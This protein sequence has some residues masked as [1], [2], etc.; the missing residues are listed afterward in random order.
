MR[1]IAE[2]WNGRRNVGLRLLGYAAEDLEF[3]RDFPGLERLDLQVPV[4][5]DLMACGMWPIV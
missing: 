4:I 3:L 1:R 5:E 2:L